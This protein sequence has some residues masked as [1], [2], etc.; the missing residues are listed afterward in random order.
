MMPTSRVV[1]P[2]LLVLLAVAIVSA[3]SV[4]GCSSDVSKVEQKKAAE[5]PKIEPIEG[6]KY[7][8]GG[9]VMKYDKYGRLR[10]SGFNGEVATPTSRGLLLG[11]KLGPD[12]KHFE[13]RT[14][15]NGRVVGKST[16]WVDEQGMLWFDDRETYDSKGQVIATQKLSY[17]D[18]SKT[19]TS[20]IEQV[21]PKTDKVIATSKQDI[22]YTPPEE[23]DEDDDAAPAQ[24]GSGNGS[25]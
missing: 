25:D 15:L 19:M 8:V 20:V 4:P 21:D 24:Q 1:R 17:D 2:G 12:G 6:M 13:Y 10:L 5:L 9:P 14:W 16:G 11:Y 7:Y 23:P 3:G 18:D 22:P